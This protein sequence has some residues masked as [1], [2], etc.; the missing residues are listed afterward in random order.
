MQLR[1]ATIRKNRLRVSGIG[2]ISAHRG[3]LAMSPLFP[4]SR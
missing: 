2:G 1:V 4:T 3:T